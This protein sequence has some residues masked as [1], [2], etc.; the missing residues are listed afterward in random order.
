M[1]NFPAYPDLLVDSVGRVARVKLNR[2]DR[3][4]SL[5]PR[6]MDDVED[7]C[8]RI[9]ADP[10]LR[11]IVLSGAGKGFSGG[12]DIA[13]TSAAG[14]RSEAPS[15]TADA[16]RIRGTADRWIRLWQ[17]PKPVIAQVHGYCIAG[18]FELAMSCDLVI[19][20]ED[21]RFGF[22][23][24]R[25]QGIP[26]LMFYPW[27]M[28]MRRAKEFLWTGDMITGRE[29]AEIGL[30]N[31]SVAPERLEEDALA[32][33]QRI[34]LMDS[35]LLTLS[36][37]ALHAAYEAMGYLDSISVGVEFDA[38][39]HLTRPAEEFRRIAREQ[40]L[41]AAVRW[42]DEPYEQESLRFGG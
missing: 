17:G 26:P 32:Y 15:I 9:Y 35:E 34:A 23:P 14:P 6:L 4:N 39:A 31:H 42:R 27:L 22:P 38:M 2:P 16:E 7:V 10:E 37:R 33:A 40:G 24:V 29:A 20:G 21:A 30:I 1:T 3:A 28:G 25:A 13:P 11:V 12:Y 5:S 19:A 8:Q 41:K 36:K 18:G